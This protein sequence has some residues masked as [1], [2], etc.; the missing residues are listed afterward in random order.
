MKRTL[1]LLS[2][3]MIILSA[4]VPVVTP[5]SAP[6]TSVALLPVDTPVLTATSA[7]TP[8]PTATPTTIAT[9]IPTMI[10]T[11]MPTATPTP[12]PTI[13]VG[14]LIVPDPRYTNPELFDLSKPEAPIPQFVN[15][16]RMAGVKI[17][18]EQLVSSFR[19]EANKQGSHVYALISDTD[20]E[21]ADGVCLLIANRLSNSAE[22]IWSKTT[23]SIYWQSLGEYEIGTV[24]EWYRTAE[25]PKYLETIRSD[26]NHLSL[27]TEFIWKYLYADGNQPNEY[28]LKQVDVALRFAQANNMSIDIEGFTWGLQLPDWL[29]QGNFTKD[30]LVQMLTRHMTLLGRYRGRFKRVNVASEPFGN[31]WETNYWGTKLGLETYL[32]IAFRAARENNPDAILT[33]VDISDSDRLYELVRRLNEQEQ[34]RNGRKLIDAVGLEMPF[35]LPGSSINIQDYLNPD[36]RKNALEGFRQNIRRYREIGV[37]VYI[38]ELLIDLTDVPGSMEEKLAFQAKLYKDFLK[39]CIEEGISVTLY[40]FYDG[41]S[42]YPQGAGRPNAAPYLRDAVYNPKPSYYSLL[43]ISLARGQ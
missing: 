28:N 13:K 30:E 17:I 32:Q 36:I 37:E 31:I 34:T 15:A 42:V 16:M 24:L 23:P 39:F 41:R 25:D 22:W 7:N 27:N 14:E 2:L 35:F 21:L 12:I 26:F 6:A 18:G 19:Y 10:A 8:T 11:A 5:T 3:A 38:T 1:S 40:S 9:T 4:C 29:I 33:L 43:S 20:N